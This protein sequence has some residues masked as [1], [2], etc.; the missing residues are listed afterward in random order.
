V[1]NTPKGNKKGG[2]RAKTISTALVIWG[3]KPVRVPSRFIF[4]HSIKNK[5]DRDRARGRELERERNR[6]RENERQKIKKDG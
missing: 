6:K 1:F 4:Y 2:N 3:R 5:I